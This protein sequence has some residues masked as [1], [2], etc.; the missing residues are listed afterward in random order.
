MAPSTCAR[1]VGRKLLQIPARLI[2][3]PIFFAAAGA[4]LNAADSVTNAAQPFYRPVLIP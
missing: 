1:Q 3:A 4:M 2:I